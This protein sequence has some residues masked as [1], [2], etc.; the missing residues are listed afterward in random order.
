MTAS[1]E[2]RRSTY[3][4]TLDS[5]ISPT[6]DV[7]EVISSIG[8]SGGNFFN[9]AAGRPL[10]VADNPEVGDFPLKERGILG[11]NPDPATFP[12]FPLLPN[13]ASVE[14]Y[15]RGYWSGTF[16]LVS[17]VRLLLTL[18]DVE[19]YGEGAYING[20]VLNQYPNGNPDLVGGTNPFTYAGPLWLKPDHP[21]NNPSVK[22]PMQQSQDPS[23]GFI[24]LTPGEG[25]TPGFPYS[26]YAVVQLVTGPNAVP[27]EGGRSSFALYYDES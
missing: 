15:F 16:T 2:F 3:D 9:W 19:G 23:Q 24:D 27:G 20:R 13:A 6:Y 26:R 12:E 21:G 14:I 17:N 1:F 7:R 11:D 8:S 25:V 5:A 4:V 22:S 18:L 10:T